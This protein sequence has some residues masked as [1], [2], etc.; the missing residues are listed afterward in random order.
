MHFGRND[1]ETTISPSHVLGTSIS[2]SQ[3]HHGSRSDPL[4]DILLHL[5]LTYQALTIAQHPNSS[6]TPFMP[7]AEPAP[8]QCTKTHATASAA[9]HRKP[10]ALS[11]LPPLA[12]MGYTVANRSSASVAEPERCRQHRRRHVHQTYHQRRQ[13]DHFHAQ[14]PT[15]PHQLRHQHRRGVNGTVTPPPARGP[16]PANPS[17]RNEGIWLAPSSSS[18]HTGTILRPFHNSSLPLQHICASP[19]P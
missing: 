12:R 15:R 6:S 5:I 4:N 2:R 11:G 13:H 7:P 1:F 14:S 8:A 19:T 3:S 17:F 18:N 9:N 16:F 10:C